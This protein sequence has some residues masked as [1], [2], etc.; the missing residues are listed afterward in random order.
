ML[1]NLDIQNL[2]SEIGAKVLH[3]HAS[4]VLI[5]EDVVYKIKKPVNFGFLDYSTYEKRLEF[6]KLELELNRR[7][8]PWIYL[9]VVP[10]SLIDSKL[11]LE[12]SSNIVES[13][14]KM[15]KIP[16]ESIMINRLDKITQSDI[17]NLANHIAS[18]HKSARICKNFQ[19]PS[20]IIYNVMENFE[21]TKEFINLTIP[22]ETFDFIKSRSEKFMEENIDIFKERANTGLIIDGHGDIRLEHVAFLKEGTCV[23]D[24]VEFNERFRCADRINDM[25]FLSMELE[26]NSRWDLSEIF[27]KAYF[28]AIGETAPK[29]LL[30]FYKSYRAYVRGKVNSL[31]AKESEHKVFAKELARKHFELSALY[32][33]NATDKNN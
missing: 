33:K 17:I 10:I 18:F 11:K 19:D 14:I 26:L 23:F 15:K 13:A 21:Q 22:K 3:T 24:C 5:L 8:C 20:V 7:L 32:I 1:T 28:N 29:E 2:A 31:L 16:E 30:Y 6:Y 27:E 12:N 9:D 4:W 25:C